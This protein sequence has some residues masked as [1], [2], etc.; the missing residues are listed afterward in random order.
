MTKIK[1]SQRDRKLGDLALVCPLYFVI[2][3]FFCLVSLVYTH[4]VCLCSTSDL[5]PSP[6]KY[7]QMLTGDGYSP[8]IL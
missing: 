4:R 2:S 5:A 6:Q 3:A 1:E 7:L 8:D